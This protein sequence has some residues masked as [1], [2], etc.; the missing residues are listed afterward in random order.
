MGCGGHSERVDSGEIVSGRPP[1][2]RRVPRGAS[3]LRRCPR[4]PVRERHVVERGHRRAPRR[5]VRGAGDEPTELPVEHSGRVDGGFGVQPHVRRELPPVHAPSGTGDALDEPH[6]READSVNERV[7]GTS[8]R[9]GH[10]NRSLLRSG[11]VGGQQRC[12]R[13]PSR[14]CFRHGGYLEVDVVRSAERRELL[15]DTS[16][17]CCR[18]DRGDRH[19]TGR[20]GGEGW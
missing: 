7:G 17:S 20:G 12:G 9:L 10:S 3:H 11:K 5:G 13:P 18:L 8:Q 6:V 4:P 16:A 15:R 19:V 2:F 1:P 14:R